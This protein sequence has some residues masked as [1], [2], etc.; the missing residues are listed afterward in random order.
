MANEEKFKAEVKRRYRLRGYVTREKVKEV[1]ED[2]QG[3]M[4]TFQVDHLLV[5]PRK[6]ILNKLNRAE[7]LIDEAKEEIYRNFKKDPLYNL[8]PRLSDEDIDRIVSKVFNEANWKAEVG[9]MAWTIFGNICQEV[10]I[11]KVGKE[12]CQIDDGKKTMFVYTELL[13]PSLDAAMDSIKI[14]N[15]K[16]DDLTRVYRDITYKK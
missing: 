14:I 12:N 13:F 16:G 6:S 1:A 2:I 10:K 5:F 3:S 7:K 4:R 15:A 9:K 8:Y 11:I